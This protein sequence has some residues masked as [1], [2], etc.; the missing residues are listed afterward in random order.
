VPQKRQQNGARTT[1]TNISQLTGIITKII[2]K[3]YGN[4]TKNGVKIIKK[5][6]MDIQESIIMRIKTNR[7]NAIMNIKKEEGQRILVIGLP[8]IFVPGHLVL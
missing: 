5:K 4:Q 2:K 3:R 1:E 8:V 7:L 6:L